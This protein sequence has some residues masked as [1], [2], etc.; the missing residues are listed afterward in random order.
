MDRTPQILIVDDDPEIRALLGDYLVRQGLRA[1]AVGDGQA[2]WRLLDRQE[3]DLIVLDLMLPG[4][5]GLELCRQ[6]RSRSDLPVI[7]LTAR[8]DATDRIV[9]L[10]LGADDYL[11]KPFD[12]RELLARIRATLR[13]SGSRERNGTASHRL[14]F[15][16]WTLDRQRH[17]LYDPDGTVVPLSSGEYRLLEIF[18]ERPNRALGRELLLDLLQGR[19]A[20]PYDRSVDVQVSRLRRRLH[21]AAR[22]P[23]L[24]KTVR[25][26]G[27]LFAAHVEPVG[28]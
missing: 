8:G 3:I 10:E 24:I 9:G 2:M 20:T 4:D 14:R 5:D 13:R 15:D 22:E 19:E 25:N 11:P 26:S 27:Y 17:E 21:D 18:V 7:M 28:D 23:R 16:G 1:H 12:P 6:L